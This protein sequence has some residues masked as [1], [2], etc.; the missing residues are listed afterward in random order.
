MKTAVRVLVLAGVLSLC[1]Q[2]A[3]AQPTVEAE[4]ATSIVDRM[5]QGSASQFPA[6]VG[7]L[8]VWT[9]VTGAGGTTMQHVWM[10]DGNEYPVAIAVGGS[11]WRTWSSKVIPTEWAGE[12]TVEIRAQDGAVLETLSFTVG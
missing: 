12:W 9:R 7:E 8:Y 6:D 3:Q 1:G 5:P 10:H 11:P 4:V 2:G